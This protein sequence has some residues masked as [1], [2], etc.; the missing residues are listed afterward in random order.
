MIKKGFL[1]YKYLIKVKFK[2]VLID[3]LFCCYGILL[4]KRDNYN[5]FISYWVLCKII[6]IYYYLE[7]DWYYW[8]IEELSIGKS[9]KL[10]FY[11]F[12]NVIV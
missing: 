4:Y 8:F 12:F 6:V 11:G 5:L 10:L 1:S 7:K 2:G 9:R 3:K